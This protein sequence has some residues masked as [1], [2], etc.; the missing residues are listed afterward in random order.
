MSSLILSDV[1]HINAYV[2]YSLFVS[3]DCAAGSEYNPATKNCV[4]CPRGYYRN[5]ALSFNCVLCPIE[6]ITANEGTPNKAGCNIGND[7]YNMGNDKY[8]IGND[9]CNIGN[10]KYNV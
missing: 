3:V 6:K 9:T 10:D 7:I 8:N 1:L 5:K 2:K 4:K